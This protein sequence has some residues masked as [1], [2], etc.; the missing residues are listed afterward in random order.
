MKVGSHLGALGALINNV[1]GFIKKDGVIAS[2]DG[3]QDTKDSEN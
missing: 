3:D 2:T 1:E